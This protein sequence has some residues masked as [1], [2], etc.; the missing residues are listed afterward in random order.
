VTTVTENTHA[1][2]IDRS[3]PSPEGVDADW[4]VPKR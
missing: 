3:I 2:E 1:S 4:S